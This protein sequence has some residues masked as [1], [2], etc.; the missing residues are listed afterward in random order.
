[1][2]RTLFIVGTPIGNLEDITERARRVLG[3]VAMVLAEDTRVTGKLLKH[4]GS[5]ASLKSVN[6][7]TARGAISKILEESE[8]DLAFVSDAGVPG[9]SDP[10]GKVVEVARAAGFAISPIPG[11]SAVTVALSVCGFPTQQFTMMGFPPQ[12]KGRNGFFEQVSEID[13]AVV[14]FES[15]YRLEKTLLQ[16]PQERLVLVGRELTKMHEEIFLDYPRN[17]LERLRSP[18]GEFTLVVAP[19]GFSLK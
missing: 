15:K 9:I 11:V 8:G 3:E 6:E 5:Q 4:L 2:D 10:G 18:K 17:I 13:H 12:K 1:M 14:L 7:H 16:L 19:A